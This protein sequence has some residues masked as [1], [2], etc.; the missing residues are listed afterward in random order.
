MPS[1]LSTASCPTL[2][3]TAEAAWTS[4]TLFSSKF[5][6]PRASQ[7]LH[8]VTTVKL[9]IRFDVIAPEG[10]KQE[11]ATA[12]PQDARCFAERHSEWL[13]LGSDHG[14]LCRPPV[15]SR[16]AK[17]LIF[18]TFSPSVEK[19]SSCRLVNEIACKTSSNDR[20]LMNSEAA[21]LSHFEATD[22]SLSAVVQKGHLQWLSPATACCPSP[23]SGRQTKQQRH[24][25]KRHYHVE[26]RS[27]ALLAE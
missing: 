22:R 2:I 11:L 15:V 3:S 26:K 7:K 17:T 23:T 13:P 9:L 12:R 1:G 6:E 5:S 19:P 20:L 27:D 25:S 8:V 24:N 10:V 14:G 21:L 16:A 4:A 18:K